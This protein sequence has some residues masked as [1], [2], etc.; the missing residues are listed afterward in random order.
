M[1]YGDQFG[2]CLELPVSQRNGREIRRSISALA[3]VA[4]MN[5]T[6]RHVTYKKSSRMFE[7]SLQKTRPCSHS[8]M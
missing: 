8:T 1:E 6:E 3:R 2:I 7:W 5:C 4:A